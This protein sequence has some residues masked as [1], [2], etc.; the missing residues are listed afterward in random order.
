MFCT[1]SI[2]LF[3]NVLQELDDHYE[4][5]KAALLASVAGQK[6]RLAAERDRQAQLVRLRRQQLLL[7][8]EDNFESAA[9]LLHAAEEQQRNK[10]AE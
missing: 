2:I 9:F 6:G 1:G 4:E 3:Q 10:S 8:K 5:E 7:D